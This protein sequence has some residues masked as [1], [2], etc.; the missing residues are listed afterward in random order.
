MGEFVAEAGI[1]R[2]VVIGQAAAAMHEA[3]ARKAAEGSWKG[4]SVL[5]PD[6]DSALGV[7]TAALPETHGLTRRDVV[8]VKASKS[9]H[10]EGVALALAAVEGVA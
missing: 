3:A 4:E 5:V 6:V 8:L 1:D 7:I 10:L 2:L 9:A